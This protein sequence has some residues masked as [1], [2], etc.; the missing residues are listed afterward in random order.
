MKVAAIIQ[1]RME[2]TRLPGKV[3]MEICGKPVLWHIVNRSLKSRYLEHVMIATSNNS[4]DDK[5]YQFALNNSID[6]YRGSQTN[7]LERF[8]RCALQY[9]PDIIVRLTGD[10][11]LIDPYIIDSGIEYFIQNEGID[12]IYYREGLPLG[13]AVEIFTYQALKTAYDEAEDDECLEH[14][15]PYLYKNSK[16]NAKRV[17]G[18][19]EDYSY[20]RWTLDTRQDYE[21]ITKIYETLYGNGER[22]FCFEDVIEQYK[23]H[24]EW[25]D[26]NSNVEQVKVTYKGD[27]KGNI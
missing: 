8:Y 23:Y 12:Y 19:G 7:V 20:L 24:T 9:E 26:I 14:V 15:T 6:V 4:A 17:P 18:L 27:T 11:A 10:N 13:M 25:K 1:A 2:S 5:I 16:F 21:L 22:L 3:L